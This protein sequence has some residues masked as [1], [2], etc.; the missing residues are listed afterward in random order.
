MGFVKYAF[1]LYDVKTQSL[2]LA[3]VLN[4]IHSKVSFYWSAKSVLLSI[5]GKFIIPISKFA[6][7][8]RRIVGG[9]VSS[10]GLLTRQIG[11]KIRYQ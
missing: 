3:V 1:K 10:L 2:E 11:F 9:V 6:I 4:F 8:I 5:N 7:S